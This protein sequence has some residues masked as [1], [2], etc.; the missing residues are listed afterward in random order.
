MSTPDRS[1]QRALA[2]VAVG[3]V[4]ILAVGLASFRLVGPEDTTFDDVARVVLQPTDDARPDDFIGNLDPAA[5]RE[6][7]DADGEATGGGGG[8]G[9]NGED[10]DG[11]DGDGGNGDPAETPVDIAQRIA[12]LEPFGGATRATGATLSGLQA[13]G[14]E[15]GL[16]SA[17]LRTPTCDVEALG[18]F[19]DDEANAATVDAWSGI[20]DIQADAPERSEDDAGEDSNGADDA[21]AADGAD[22]P[23]ETD[24]TAEPTIAEYIDGLTPVRLRLDTRVTS[25]GFADGQTT[26]FQ[27]I[28]QSGTPVLVDN[29]GVPRVACNSG[30]PLSEP[31]PLGDL[32][33]EHAFE[34]EAI[35]DDPEAAWL[36]LDPEVVVTVVPG[37]ETVDEFTLVNIDDGGLLERPVGTNGSRDF[38]ERDFEATLTWDSPAD[39]DVEA[40][41]PNGTKIS[42]ENP[43]PASS[44][45]ELDGD[46]NHRCE[47]PATGE[48]TIS[49]PDGDAPSGDYQI[50]VRG[51]AV[52]DGYAHDCGGNTA[53]YT[54]TIKLFGQDDQVHEGSLGDGDTDEYS[55]AVP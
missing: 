51:F 40:V 38:G 13:P 33:E 49:W 18:E 24:E 4:I 50:I 45:G 32:E 30:N 11:E 8:N 35:A 23:D 36:G 27:S 34:L 42:P 28:L 31:D 20:L 3:S 25:H 52:G 17:K 6:A 55:A 26:R 7:D 22:E 10:G 39:L 14:T 9:G 29:T 48:E 37:P 19:L 16:Y 41:E 15:P 21:D 43:A 54:L 47:G 12:I 44:K 53:S 46:A 2:S 1:S 5:P